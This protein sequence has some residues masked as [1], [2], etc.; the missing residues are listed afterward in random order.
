MIRKIVAQARKGFTLTEVA[1]VLGIMGLILGAIWVA[2]SS[3]YANQRV[4]KANTELMTIAQNIRSTFATQAQV[5]TAAST[6][7]TTSLIRAGVFPTD[8]INGGN[9]NTATSV[10]SPWNLGT[11]VVYSM[12]VNTTGDAFEI[13][14]RN[15]PQAA[16]I[17]LLTA[18]GGTGRDQGMMMA[19][20]RATAATAM[21][22][23]ATTFPVTATNAL[24]ACPSA[25][26]DAVFV[27]T[28]RG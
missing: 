16:C 9:P 14:F 28:L 19:N 21:P 23:A 15:I 26:D 13:Q 20:G 7:I 2:A 24:A 17:S 12:T 1:I 18:V 22:Y 8:A 5:D 27:F 6:D 4:S 3:V 25:Q 10:L 11:I